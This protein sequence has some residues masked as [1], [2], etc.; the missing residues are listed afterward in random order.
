MDI[1]KISFTG[2][3]AT[4]KKVSK[5][6]LDS[7]LKKCTLELGGKSAA[8]VFADADIPNAVGSTADGFLANSG[9]ICAAASRLLVEE[10]I[11]PAFIDAVKER[12]SVASGQTGSDPRE[13]TTVYGPVADK[14]Q[15]DTVMSFIEKGKKDKEPIIGGKQKGD[16]GWFI[17]PTIFVDPDTNNAIYREEIFGPVLVIKTFKTEEEAIQIANDTNTGLSG[18]L[19]DQKKSNC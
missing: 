11:A 16:K 4:G 13:A 8:L 14:S 6:A 15:F 1:K 9:Q 3:T 19:I 10:S 5:L 2:S 18:S 7:N 17:E 12:F